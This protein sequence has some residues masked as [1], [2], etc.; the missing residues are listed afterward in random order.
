MNL[1]KLTF[2]QVVALISTLGGVIPILFNLIAEASEA[3]RQCS[4]LIAPVWALALT[5]FGNLAA[6]F[7]KSLV[8]TLKGK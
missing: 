7:S 5:V 6:I 8:D 4:A 3:I 2:G 1:G